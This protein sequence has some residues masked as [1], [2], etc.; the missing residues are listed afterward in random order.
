MLVLNIASF[1][2]GTHYLH[3]TPDAD[4]LGL[5]PD[6]FS[7]IRVSVQLN[8]QPNH[9]DLL[10]SINAVASLVCDRTLNL[11]KQ[12]IVGEHHIIFK[13]NV[14]HQNGEIEFRTYS[15]DQYELDITEA[16]RDTLLLA[17]P[18]KRVS[19]EAENMP[20]TVQC[21]GDDSDVQTDPRG[22]ALNKLKTE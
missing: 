19:P 16:V 6:L 10:L 5:N 14:T 13:D 20:P 2:S 12:P 8:I 22:E 1:G 21:G 7:E 9:T 17:L 18:L 11:F 3:L 4:A 15:R